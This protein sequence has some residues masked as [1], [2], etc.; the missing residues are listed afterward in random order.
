MLTYRKHV[1]TTALKCKKSMSVLKAMA[2]KCIEHHHLF[3]LHQR[4]V[5]GVTGYGRGLTTM[6]WANLLKLDRVQNEAT[7]VMLGTTNRTPTETLKFMLDL[8]LMQIR[9]RLSGASQSILQ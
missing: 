9:L 6:A 5:L 8:P 4:V 1:E 2:T 3:L 7:I